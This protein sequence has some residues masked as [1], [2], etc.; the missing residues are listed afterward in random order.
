MN[1][2]YTLDVPDPGKVEYKPEMA[3][4]ALGALIL[5]A[6]RVFIGAGEWFE[7]SGSLAVFC[8]AIAE[9]IALNRLTKKHFLNACRAKAGE[10]PWGLTTAYKIVG[11]LAFALGLTGTVIWGFGSKFP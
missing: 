4:L 2:T 1:K 11:W 9:F 3:F 6:V 10:T 8:A 7:R 5:I